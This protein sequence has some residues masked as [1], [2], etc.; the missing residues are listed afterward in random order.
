M[1]FPKVM[2]A[3]FGSGFI[4]VATLSA[5]SDTF[6]NKFDRNI[7]KPIRNYHRNSVDMNRLMMEEEFNDFLC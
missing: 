1:G 3:V 6:R 5:I 4:G 2:L 7:M